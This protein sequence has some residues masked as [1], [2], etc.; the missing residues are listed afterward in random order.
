MPLLLLAHQSPLS[1]RR[2]RYAL[3]GLGDF[4]VPVAVDTPGYGESDSPPG[5]WEVADYA[6]V[7]WHVADALG[8]ER[9]WLFGR[10]TGAVFA[11]HAAALQPNR[12]AGVMLHGVPVYT[13]DEKADRLATF[14]PPYEANVDGR[15]LQWI[16]SRVQSEY[17]WADAQLLTELV[18][19]YLSAGPDFANSYRAIWRHDLAASLSELAP[20]DLLMT[21]TDDRIG[22]M[23]ERAVGSI[24]HRRAVVL[25]GAT[26]FV[27]EQDPETFVATLR[28]VMGAGGAA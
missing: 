8:H 13:S 12:L 27:A 11:L 14:A 19:D 15:H 24:R 23:H 1:S 4:C 3:D 25:P 2:Y 10:A 18:R 5:P 16:W 28:D 21:G 7:L 22:Y 26:D 6:K 9:A 20:V 17:P